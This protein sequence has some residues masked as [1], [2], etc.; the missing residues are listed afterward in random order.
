[1]PNSLLGTTH[2]PPSVI[3]IRLAHTSIIQLFQRCTSRSTSGVR[4]NWS[5]RWT[6]R[7]WIDG[8]MSGESSFVGTWFSNPNSLFESGIFASRNRLLLHLNSIVNMAKHH[9]NTIP[10]S[11]IH[12]RS[13]PVSPCS[14]LSRISKSHSNC[15][16]PSIAQSN[17]RHSRL[18]VGIGRLQLDPT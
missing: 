18:C 6:R 12:F 13:S 3:S 16:S 14:P 7:T 8:N 15:R 1:L 2:F 9:R 11:L 5:R 10:S 4:N 17:S